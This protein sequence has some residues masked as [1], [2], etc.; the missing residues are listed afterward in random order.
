M[1]LSHQLVAQKSPSLVTKQPQTTE[2][3]ATDPDQQQQAAA[4][5]LSDS[6]VTVLE[7]VTTGSML[8]NPSSV[9]QVTMPFVPQPLAPAAKCLKVWADAGR[10][11]VDGYVR[12]R[13]VGAE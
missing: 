6:P 8:L 3:S 5:V 9:Q 13:R 7:A 11:G 2:I 12:G 4:A 10:C 1:H